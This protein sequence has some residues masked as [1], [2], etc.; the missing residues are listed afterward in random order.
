M[1]YSLPVPRKIVDIRPTPFHKTDSS[2]RHCIDFAL[3]IGTPVKAVANGVVRCRVSR[4]AKTY[5]N[6]RYTDRVNYVEILHAD[7]RVS[8]YLHLKWR[9]VRVRVGQ[10]VRRGQ[11]IA[12]SGNTGYATYPHLHFG[13]Y[14]FSHVDS[15]DYYKNIPVQFTG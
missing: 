1:R 5:D 13:L 3:P 4:F 9:S 14:D 10:K 12:L 7:G 15:C 11:I 6:S 2:I 8:F